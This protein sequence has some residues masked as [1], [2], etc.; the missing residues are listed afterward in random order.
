M[1]FGG[2]LWGVVKGVLIEGVKHVVEKIKNWIFDTDDLKDAPVYDEENATMD[3]TKKINELLTQQRAGFKKAIADLETSCKQHAEKVFEVLL[4]G[5][6]QIQNEHG[7]KINYDY[8]QKKID[9]Y[10]NQISGGI[11]EHVNRRLTVSDPECSEILKLKGEERSRAIDTFIRK[12]I[13]NGIDEYLLELER[14]TNE[15]IDFVSA[16][17]GSKVEYLKAST[18]SLLKEIESLDKDFSDSELS[19]K[20]E[21]CSI[22]I[23]KL[24][25]FIESL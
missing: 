12:I 20:K 8:L 11:S 7:L 17:I 4:R 23:K 13:R 24:D 6:T 10:Y 14:T 21:E 16:F 2:S 15:S 25:T 22:R 3:E 18:E 1:G 5:V 19:Q 9:G